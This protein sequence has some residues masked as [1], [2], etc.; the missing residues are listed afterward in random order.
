MIWRQH[1]KLENT[2]LSLNLNIFMYSEEPI[3]RKIQGTRSCLT[4]LNLLGEISRFLNQQS[5]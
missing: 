3:A 1:L 5:G 4:Q 2:E